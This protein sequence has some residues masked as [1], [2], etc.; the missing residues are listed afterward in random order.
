MPT[1]NELTPNDI[2]RSS[3]PDAVARCLSI[4]RN[5]RFRFEYY[6]WPGGYPIIYITEDGGIIC[7]DCCNSEQ[8]LIRDAW[9]RND[10][11]GGWYVVTPDIHY[12]GIE[13]C[14]NCGKV[15]DPAYQEDMK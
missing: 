1:W 11:T 7:P 15:C 8:S 5:H 9:K 4:A 13:H 3:I 14:D 2:K 6:S 12:E 10:N